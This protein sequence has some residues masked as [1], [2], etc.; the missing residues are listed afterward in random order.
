MVENLNDSVIDKKKIKEQI[1][2]RDSYN[3]V[4]NRW[5]LEQLSVYDYS[6]KIETR[7]LGDS[8][9]LDSAT[10]GVLDTNI[11]GDDTAGSWVTHQDNTTKQK[12]TNAGKD[13]IVKWLFSDTATAPTHLAWG[14]G[15]G[16]F[17]ITQ[18]ALVNESERLSL[19]TYSTVSYVDASGTFPLTFPI[20][21]E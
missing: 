10:Q 19:D 17:N 6:F 7:T 8:F 13:Q 15:S 20:T 14:I 3:F 16:S 12:I 4:L 18:T 5:K 2:K 9:V 1:G 11:L 21:F